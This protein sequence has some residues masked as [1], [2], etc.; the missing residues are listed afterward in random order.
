MVIPRATPTVTRNVCFQE[1]SEHLYC[2]DL[3]RTVIVILL[4]RTIIIFQMYARVIGFR[5]IFSFVQHL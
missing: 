1:D 2:V 3:G 4:R 5:N